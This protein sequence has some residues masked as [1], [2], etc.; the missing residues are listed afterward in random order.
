M[1]EVVWDLR[2]QFKLDRAGEIEEGDHER[3]AI[4]S[5]EE[6]RLGLV[7]IHKRGHVAWSIYFEDG[8]SGGTRFLTS[9]TR[10]V[11]LSEEPSK[12]AS[13]QRSLARYWNSFLCEILHR[14]EK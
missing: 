10:T 5:K 7:S 8:D 12:I 11:M 13:S 9:M 1:T 6:R 14:R 2:R 3:R 4:R